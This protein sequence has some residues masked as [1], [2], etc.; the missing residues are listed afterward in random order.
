LRAIVD[1][2]N[3][4]AEAD[5]D[6]NETDVEVAISGD[7]VQ[8]LQNVTPVLPPLPSVSLTSPGNGASLS[9]TVGLTASTPGTLGV[10]FLL[11][12]QPLGGVVTAM[13]YA[14]AWDSRTALNGGH[15]IAVQT[16]DSNGR[17]NT[18]EIA[19]V[20]VVNALTDTV[21]PVVQITDP[22]PGDTVSATVTIGG[23]A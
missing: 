17:T 19:S 9:G 12:G 21:P 4:L 15:W 2:D 23:M 3:F 6:N 5:E 22:P 13:P 14:L 18:S 20:T 1:P 7:S 11:D 16:T 10:Q 8:V